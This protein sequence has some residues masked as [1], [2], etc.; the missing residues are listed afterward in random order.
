VQK[1]LN[2]FVKLNSSYQMPQFEVSKAKN[3]IGEEVPSIRVSKNGELINLQIYGDSNEFAKINNTIMSESEIINF[4]DLLI[5]DSKPEFRGYPEI[6]NKDWKLMTPEQRAQYV[7]NMRLMWNDAHSVLLEAKKINKK[8]K[9]AA[10]NNIFILFVQKVMAASASDGRNCLIAGYV[11]PDN[12]Q[13]CDHKKIK[14][15]YSE[16]MIFKDASAFCKGSQI[17]CNPLVFG[18]PNGTPICI[19]PSSNNDFQIGTHYEGP[20]ERN[21]HLGSKVQFLKDEN[22]KQGRYESSN[23]IKDEAEIQAQLKKDQTES[24]AATKDFIEGILKFKN[25]ELV[26]AFV[27]G[28]MSD[29]LLNKLKE[30][31]QDFNSEIREAKKACK[32]ASSDNQQRSI[33][34][35]SACDQMQRRSIF[36][37]EYLSKSPGCKNGQSVNT[38]SLRCAC[39]NSKEQEVNPGAVCTPVVALAAEK[40]PAVITVAEKTEVKKPVVKD[41]LPTKPLTEKTKAKIEV[42]KEEESSVMSTLKTATPWIAGVLALAG[43]Y[44]WLK[45]AYNYYTKKTCADGKPAPCKCRLGTEKNCLAIGNSAQQ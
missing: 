28:E 12:S 37:A 19:T 36:V 44:W 25:K 45:P 17:A 11:I 16:S 29:V 40:A 30:I 38:E 42:K 22:K 20:C 7:L 41:E 10:L 13:V 4:T 8:N 14:S 15:S 9:S 34:F 23:I 2:A 43:A 33:N 39:L 26:D 18:T 24:L 3:S 5:E 31:R 6:S 27:K 35:W 21:N 32:S 1:K